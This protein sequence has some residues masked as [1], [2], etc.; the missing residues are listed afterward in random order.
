MRSPSLDRM[1]CRALAR[2]GNMRA[3]STTTTRAKRPWAQNIRAVSDS[4]GQ[5][6]ENFYRR[7][8]GFPHRGKTMVPVPSVPAFTRLYGYDG[9]G[10]V[11]QLTSSTGATTDTYDYDGLRQPSQLHGQQRRTTTYSPASKM[12]PHLVSTTTRPIPS[13][14]PRVDSGILTQ[15]RGDDERPRLA[16]QIPLQP[17]ETRWINLDPTGN[18]IDAVAAFSIGRHSM[19]CHSERI[20]RFLRKRS[21]AI[22]RPTGY[23]RKRTERCADFGC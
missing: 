16:E 8:V 11:R 7:V 3:T 14:P 19:H 22:N 6:H 12:T 4:A 10:S 5:A 17:K 23:R 15:M 21:G 1:T 18:E 2:W 20:R 9:H 13:I